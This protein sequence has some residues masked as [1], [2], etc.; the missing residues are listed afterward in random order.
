MRAKFFHFQFVMEVLYK[1][2]NFGIQNY[3]ENGKQ[4]FRK[5]KNRDFKFN[6]FQNQIPYQK[7]KINPKKFRI[8]QNYIF[9]KTSKNVRHFIVIYITKK[10]HAHTL[11]F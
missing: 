10:I 2:C 7:S 1:L 11:S 5:S 4:K 3:R 6:K 9:K 8:S